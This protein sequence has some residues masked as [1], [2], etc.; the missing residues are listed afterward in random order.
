MQ[1]VHSGRFRSGTATNVDQGTSVSI[2]GKYAS[3]QTY[4]ATEEDSTLTGTDQS[5][6]FA[7]W[8]KVGSNAGYRFF[9]INV[10]DLLGGDDLLDLTNAASPYNLSIEAY[11]G[12]GNDVL[13]ASGG[14]DYMQGD[15]GNDSLWGGA[16]EDW[17]EGDDWQTGATGID[18]VFGGPG[19]DTLMGSY[20][21]A[22]NI[23]G[24]V[25][26]GLPDLLDGGEGND[27]LWGMPNDT[28]SGGGGNDTLIYN[29]NDMSDAAPFSGG[30]G[31]DVLTITLDAAY[32]YDW[33]FET[34][35]AAFEIE[36][37]SAGSWINRISPK[38]YWTVSGPRSYDFSTTKLTRIE[39]IGGGYGDDVIVGP[40][41][42]SFNEEGWEDV[43]LAI[44]GR[45]GNDTL[46]AGAS[47]NYD[48]IGGDGNDVVTG[49]PGNDYVSGDKGDD[50]LT[51][52]GGADIFVFSKFE[53]LDLGTDVITDFNQSQ[54]D[55]VGVWF[56]GKD[57]INDLIITYQPDG[58]RVEIN[59]TTILFLR[60]FEG[61]TLAEA[62]FYFLG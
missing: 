15:G 24:F 21:T 28:L 4:T 59:P 1:F 31:Y 2:A 43:E 35:S 62:D 5:E 52:G 48:L 49:G 29:S 51:G 53:G 32:E 33:F 7:Y 39:E 13:W 22:S 17:L 41:S 58:A 50:W 27:E 3:L 25:D 30:A 26:D 61:S 42:Y 60:G 8:L 18:T 45:N 56:Y 44:W 6:V 46:S 47:G 9:G 34:W 20:A 38:Y 54:G 57:N 12:T 16:G 10:F 11:G 14:D 55:R 19:N 23:S 40:L 36:E 37:I